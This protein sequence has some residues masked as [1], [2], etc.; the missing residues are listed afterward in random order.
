MALGIK[1]KHFGFYNN[2]R[3]R[4]FQVRDGNQLRYL[5]GEQ[6]VELQCCHPCIKPVIENFQAVLMFQN[7]EQKTRAI[8]CLEKIRDAYK[9][10]LNIQANL[11]EMYKQTKQTKGEEDCK[12]NIER[13]LHSSDKDLEKA[14]SLAEQGYILMIDLHSETTDSPEKKIMD[15]RDQV[16]EILESSRGRIQAAG[17]ES[18]LKD[19]TTIRKKLLGLHTNCHKETTQERKRAVKK[20]AEAI[21]IFEKIIQNDNTISTEVIVWKHYLGKAYHRLSGG[22]DEILSGLDKKIYIKK[23]VEYFGQVAIHFQSKVTDDKESRILART[24]AYIACIYIQKKHIIKSDEH[25]G[26]LKVKDIIALQEPMRVAALAEEICSTHPDRVT[27]N[28]LGILQA[29]GKEWSKAEEYYNK[30]IAVCSDY[31]WFAYSLLCQLYLDK[32]VDNFKV[33]KQESRNSEELK[34]AKEYG[35]ISLDK[36][37]TSTTL[38]RLAKVCKYMG[39]WKEAIGYLHTA[40]CSHE[41][42]KHHELYAILAYCYYQTKNVEGA[43]HVMKIAITIEP[44]NQ[45]DPLNFR[46]FLEFLLEEFRVNFKKSK[47]QNWQRKKKDLEEICCVLEE[48]YRKHKQRIKYQWINVINNYPHETVEVIDTLIKQTS[49]NRRD[50]LIKMGLKA[51]N[52]HKGEHVKERARRL[53][54]KMTNHTHQDTEV[55][56]DHPSRQIS[57]NLTT[58]DE[59]YRFDFYVLFGPSERSWVEN[60]F[61]DVIGRDFNMTESRLEGLAYKRGHNAGNIF[62]QCRMFVFVISEDFK[63]TPEIANIAQELKT[64]C[65]DNKEERI[66]P[67]TR[68]TEMPDFLNT[69]EPGDADDIFAIRSAILSGLNERQDLK[70]EDD[71]ADEED[72]TSD[73]ENIEQTDET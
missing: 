53:G 47:G 10:N 39:E 1:E 59:E 49:S 21:K 71:D 9:Q 4:I 42:D 72:N 73:E 27:F 19:V 45:K 8:E 11:A 36:R 67:V 65:I 2:L 20:L 28:R 25:W 58:T 43:V 5:E 30:S 41:C 14:R 33:S 7:P 57:R 63:T 23:A 37:K 40:L 34:K 60:I 26:K 32:H 6:N 17:C 3:L 16:K 35:E 64:L 52:H 13:I 29:W 46:Q 62:K 38:C 18:I 54:E 66:I 24:Y 50:T 31:N 12:K 56:I 48:A 44:K 22:S 70:D 55:S 61:M 51:L 69:L 68:D 15:F